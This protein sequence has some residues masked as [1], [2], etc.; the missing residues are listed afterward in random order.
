LC[1]CMSYV[2]LLDGPN[3]VGL[4]CWQLMPSVGCYAG[5]SGIHPACCLQ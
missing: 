5:L 2:P 1:K 4:Y 3:L